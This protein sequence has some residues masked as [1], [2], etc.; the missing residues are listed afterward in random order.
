LKAVHYS[1]EAIGRFLTDD[2]AETALSA[3]LCGCAA[4]RGVYERA[5]E[6]AGLFNGGTLLTGVTLSPEEWIYAAAL[7]GGDTFEGMPDVLADCGVDERTAAYERARVALEDKDLVETA[8]DGTVGIRR[9]LYEILEICL[10]FERFLTLTRKTPGKPDRVCNVYEKNGVSVV[11]YISLRKG[12]TAVRRKAK[13]RFAG[14]ALNGGPDQRGESFSGESFSIEELRALCEAAQGFGG[15]DGGG[16]TKEV[17]AAAMRGSVEYYSVTEIRAGANRR[18]AFR[19]EVFLCTCDR[20]LG[21]DYDADRKVY[22]VFPAR[23]EGE[24][25]G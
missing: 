1:A 8:F 20:C 21:I 24:P 18:G 16:G 6:A 13:I 9:R 11:M 15:F 3:H 25:I 5:A 10:R 12:C 7:I 22:R 19:S 17:L 2:R 23:K 14:G 4:C